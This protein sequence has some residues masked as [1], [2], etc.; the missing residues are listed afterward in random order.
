MHNGHKLI[1]ISDEVA[2]KKE[3]F[4]IENEMKHFNEI[5]DKLSGLKNKI[6][7]EIMKINNMFDKAI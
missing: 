5:S 4:S 3:N 6:E 7:N 1:E 2:L